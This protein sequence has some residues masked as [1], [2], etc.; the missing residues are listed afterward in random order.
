LN[1]DL[2]FESQSL[3]ISV[4]LCDLN[5]FQINDNVIESDFTWFTQLLHCVSI[6]CRLR[7]D[8]LISLKKPLWKVIIYTLNGDNIFENDRDFKEQTNTL[9]LEFKKL[10]ENNEINYVIKPNNRTLGEDFGKQSNIVK[11]LITSTNIN[12]ILNG[13][14]PTF[15]YDNSIDV[16]DKKYF[17]VELVLKNASKTMF[18][19]NKYFMVV[20]IDT[21]VT[22]EI[23]D[24]HSVRLFAHTIQKFRKEMQLSEWNP[25][26][27]Y[28][29]SDSEEFDK[30]IV[31]NLEAIIRKIEYPIIN[32]ICDSINN[33]SKIIN[34]VSVT[35]WIKVL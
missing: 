7:C 26:E 29:K 16:I 6:V 8:S 20:S 1:S 30:L 5:S 12:E 19:D 23:T 21:N 32:K 14:F 9:N 27:V 2:S 35:I 28:Y 4:H 31:Q 10:E 18:A 33:T 15:N 17:D 25:I 24:S 11:K 3:P 34:G 22:K 13:N